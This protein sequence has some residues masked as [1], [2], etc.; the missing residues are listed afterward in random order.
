M[1][2]TIA[3]FVMAACVGGAEASG[4]LPDGRWSVKLT[5]QGPHPLCKGSIG[6]VGEI[7]GGR[8][9]YSGQAV[10]TFSVTPSGVLIASGSRKTDRA[11]AYGLIRGEV[12]RGTFWIPTR[13][14]RGVWEALR[15]GA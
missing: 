13:N 8:P 6:T 14:C 4:K 7:R 9:V 3:F 1:R 5:G 11:S 12:A 2:A 15:V 10:Y